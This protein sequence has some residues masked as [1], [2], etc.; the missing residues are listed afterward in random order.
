MNYQYNNQFNINDFNDGKFQN[1][2]YWTLVNKLLTQITPETR[3]QILERLTE[4]N[5]QLLNTSFSMGPTD[6]ARMGQINSRKKDV[7]EV[8]HPSLD[9]Y[10]YKGKNPLPIGT[11]VNSHNLP[12]N[13]LNLTPS[14]MPSIGPGAPS[15]HKPPPINNY[16]PQKYFMPENTEPD[17]DDIIDELKS[18]LEPS[19]EDKLQKINDL[20]KK[21][22]H[23]KK[24]RKREKENNK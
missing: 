7:Y 11:P 10:N 16:G 8:Q 3:K 24:Q 14:N 13:G 5:N 20:H 12:M 2:D 1:T 21:I 19:L 9:P 23:T 18:D 6:P 4:M 17:L 15:I 22:L